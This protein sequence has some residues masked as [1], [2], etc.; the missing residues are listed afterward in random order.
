MTAPLLTLAQ[1]SPETVWLS[2]D[3]PAWL[4]RGL[5]FVLGTICGSFVNVCVHRLPRYPHGEFWPALRG[6]WTPPS[7]CPRCR[8]PIPWHDNIPVLGWLLLR[9]RCRTCRMAISPQYPLVEL[10]NGLLLLLLYWQEVPIGRQASLTESSLFSELGPQNVPGL[11]PLAPEVWIH[12]RFLYHVVLIEALLAASLIDLRLMIIPDTVT[13]PALA[14]GV[15]GSVLVGRLNIVPVWFQDPRLSRELHLVLPEGLARWLGDGPA[16][17]AWIAAH[18]HLH[19]LAV[20]LAG[21]IV[22]AGT[23]WIVRVIGTWILRREAMGDGDVVLMGMVGS[24][25]GWQPVLVAFFLAPVLVFA[26]FVVR[27]LL[28]LA[29]CMTRSHASQIRDEIP[30][31]PY[32]ALGTLVTLLSWNRLGPW[33]EQR[34][35][36]LGPLLVLMGVTGVILFAVLL[37][38]LQFAKRALGWPIGPPAAEGVWTAADQTHFFAGEQVDRFTNRWRRPD[39]WPGAAAARGSLHEERWRSRGL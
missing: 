11:G 31:G 35:F 16:A 1:A 36:G 32:L 30:Y 8:T 2:I 7:S 20:S 17:P 33:L 6:L 13:L 3:L 38:G 15:A 19:G 22:G 23:V 10:L 14:V 24:F 26:A 5:V 12:L 28:R 9:G 21:V 4:M 25:V 18:P 34:V 29:L 27:L 39:Y 37:L